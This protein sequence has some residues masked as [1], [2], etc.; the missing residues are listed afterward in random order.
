[1][2]T[3]QALSLLETIQHK[4]QN[5]QLLLPTFSSVAIDIRNALTTGDIPSAEEIAAI[6]SNDPAT[7]SRLLQV[8][9]S[10]LYNNGKKIN[11]LTNAVKLLG[12]STT[13]QLV[14]SFVIQQLFDGES[15]QQRQ[16]LQYIRELSINVA[17]M[18]RA[19]TMF[20]PHLNPEVAMLAGLIHQIG[21][22]PILKYYSEV[23]PDGCDH[24]ILNSVLATTHAKL[25]HQLLTNWGFPKELADVP[26]HYNNFDRRHANSADYVDLVQ[27]AFLQSIAGSDHPDA[28]RDWSVVAA[29]SQLGFHPD[30]TVLDKTV[31]HNQFEWA[32]AV[33]SA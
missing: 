2:K 8:A 18:S 1:M 12:N 23:E 6:V 27:V 15:S 29:F 11:R 22:L 14:S 10:P 25:G 9:N 19:F 26:L 20:T 13:S 21:T 7:A 5:N 4:I 32:K 30:M 16:S 33:L 28:G 31:L 17:S 3:E 24:R